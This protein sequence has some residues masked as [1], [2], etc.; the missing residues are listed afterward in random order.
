MEES[1]LAI[2]TCWDAVFSPAFVLALLFSVVDFKKRMIKAK[3]ERFTLKSW[4]TCETPQALRP[5]SV[6]CPR[7]KRPIC[8]ENQH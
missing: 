2:T 1:Y 4:G 8:S 7:R 5:E 6:H 3:D